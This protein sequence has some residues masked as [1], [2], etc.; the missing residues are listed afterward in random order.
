DY[1]VTVN[2]NGSL[3]VQSNLD[4]D[5]G[6]DLLLGIELLRFDGGAFDAALPLADTQFDSGPWSAIVTQTDS[7]GTML[8]SLRIAGDGREIETLYTN[9]VVSTTDW[10][11]NNDAYGWMRKLYTHD[12]DGNIVSERVE[13]DNGTVQVIDLVDG[14]PTR[15]VKTDTADAFGWDS[16]IVTYDA[17]GDIASIVV[18]LDDGR[19]RTT[20]YTNGQRSG[21]VET[22]G[23]DAR[24]W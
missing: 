16:S 17:V 7:D 22:D 10:R 9:G 23:L 20:E 21:F 3:T 15:R 18:Q 24:P 4:A 1:T 12:A 8:R 11:D 19:V 14:I 6:I 13:F 2:P 5:L